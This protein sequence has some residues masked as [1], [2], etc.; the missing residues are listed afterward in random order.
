MRSIYK[1]HFD[2]TWRHTLHLL[3]FGQKN[4]KKCEEKE[5]EGGRKI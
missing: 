4:K 3:K 5:D 1:G 2:L